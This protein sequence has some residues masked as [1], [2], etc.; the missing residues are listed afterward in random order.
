[1]DFI[2]RFG[3]ASGLVLIVLGLICYIF[4][5]QVVAFLG[6]AV[7]IVIFLAGAYFLIGYLMM[8]RE[9]DKSVIRLLCGILLV[10]CG[11]Y[12]MINTGLMIR[13]VGVFIGVMA[14]IAGANRFSTAGEEYHPVM[15]AASRPKEVTLYSVLF[16]IVMCI[17]PT[18]GVDVLVMLAGFYLI[19]SGIMVLIS[20]L[21]YHDL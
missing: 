13:V 3:V 15:P 12:L 19:I 14:F 21:K 8:K 20:V 11:I 10:I 4:R 18:W 1:M 7:G 16:G 6:V 9:S 5:S 17:A 2:R